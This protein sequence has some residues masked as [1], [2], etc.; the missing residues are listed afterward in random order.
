MELPPLLEER[1]KKQWTRQQ[2][3]LRKEDLQMK[4]RAIK[5]TGRISGGRE[6][7]S[8]E[9]FYGEFFLENLSLD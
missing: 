5:F 9:T 3:L 6:I 8:P 1:F 7:Y 4:Y 2:V